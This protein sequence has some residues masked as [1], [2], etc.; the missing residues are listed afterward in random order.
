MKPPP[1]VGKAVGSRVEDTPLAF[2]ADIYRIKGKR[3]LYSGVRLE[4]IAKRNP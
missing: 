3:S 2:V 1:R 4:K